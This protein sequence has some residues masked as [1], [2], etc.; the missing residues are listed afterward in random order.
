MK[1]GNL[2]VETGK[3]QSSTEENRY[4]MLKLSFRPSLQITYNII[5]VVS[6]R[7]N[8]YTITKHNTTILKCIGCIG[9]P[10]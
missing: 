10:L 9:T 3:W 1:G 2:K 6:L 5:Y 4:I 8:Q 7:I